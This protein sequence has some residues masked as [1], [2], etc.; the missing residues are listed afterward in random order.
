MCK[1]FFLTFRKSCCTIASN[2]VLSHFAKSWEE[3]QYFCLWFRKLPVDVRQS[4][5]Q[6]EL[7]SELPIEG[8][9]AA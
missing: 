3:E 5:M 2:R 1:K 8:R 9:K 7:T 6:K 4:M